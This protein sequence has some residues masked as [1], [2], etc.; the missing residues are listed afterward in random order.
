MGA[1]DGS[2]IKLAIIAKKMTPPKN[3]VK[4]KRILLKKIITKYG[5]RRVF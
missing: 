2:G 5:F 4:I 1:S 3:C